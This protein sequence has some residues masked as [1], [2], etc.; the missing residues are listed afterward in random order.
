MDITEFE[1]QN[2]KGTWYTLCTLKCRILHLCRSKELHNPL[3]L[4]H[5]STMVKVAA[6]ATKQF[7]VNSVRTWLRRSFCRT[8]RC[9]R[10]RCRRGPGLRFAAPSG[11]CPGPEQHS[12]FRHFPP[13]I[14]RL[15]LYRISGL[16]L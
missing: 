16:F 1:V 4:A 15:L 9:S 6:T 3:Q 14:R 5:Y 11:G 7:G 2:R 10:P 12:H 8:R 13:R